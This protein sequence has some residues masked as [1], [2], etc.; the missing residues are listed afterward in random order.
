MEAAVELVA[1]AALGSSVAFA[2]TLLGAGVAGAFAGAICFAAA[3]LAL[4]RLASRPTWRLPE[5]ELPD[6]AEDREEL[7]LDDVLAPPGAD[8]RVVQ[9]FGEGALPTPGELQAQ[10]D[11]HLAQ[12]GSPVVAPES[13]AAALSQ[14]LAE[15]RRSLR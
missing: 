2:T 14:A 7:L 5:F 10:I 15:L 3:F 8:S 4:R 11:R 6:L 9:L 1:C 12:R 13:A